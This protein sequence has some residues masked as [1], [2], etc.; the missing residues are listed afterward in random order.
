M[1]IPDGI[2]ELCLLRVRIRCYND[3]LRTAMARCPARQG[4]TLGKQELSPAQLETSRETFTYMKCL[5]VMTG[6]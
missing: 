4:L 5:L 2:L 6:V 1:L 3:W